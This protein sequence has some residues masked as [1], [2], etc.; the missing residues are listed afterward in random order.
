M[1]HGAVVP[2]TS[3]APY[4]PFWSL[5]WVPWA[6]LVGTVACLQL[7]G[8][9]L[10]GGQDGALSGRSL[11]ASWVLGLFALLSVLALR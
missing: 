7:L 11:A 10:I 2:L 5:P 8:W 6:V 9:R 1:H 4:D 3:Y